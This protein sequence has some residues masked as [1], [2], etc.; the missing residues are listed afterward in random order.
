L[1][2]IKGETEAREGINFTFASNSPHFGLLIIAR[3]QLWAVGE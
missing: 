1:R 2:D 3:L